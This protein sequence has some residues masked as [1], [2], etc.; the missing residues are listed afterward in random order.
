MSPPSKGLKELEECDDEKKE[1]P[2]PPLTPL[3]W[4]CLNAA[5]AGLKNEGPEGAVQS[6][7]GV[8]LEEE[9]FFQ[10]EVVLLLLLKLVLLAGVEVNGVESR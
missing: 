5:C 6:A 4:V 2:P 7:F 3:W 9:P 1:L 8:E 10:F